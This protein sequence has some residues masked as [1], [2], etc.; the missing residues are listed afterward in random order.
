[1]T[2][3]RKIFTSNAISMSIIYSSIRSVYNK[4]ISIPEDLSK[5]QYKQRTYICF[6]PLENSS[7]STLVLRFKN[8]D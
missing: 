3:C 5:A 8:V 6:S 4:G 2:Y 7:M 1:M